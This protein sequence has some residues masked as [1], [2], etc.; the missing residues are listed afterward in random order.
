MSAADR[1]RDDV[2]FAMQ[3]AEE[4]GGPEGAE[5]IGLMFAIAEEAQR[6]AAAYGSRLAVRAREAEVE[7]G[8]A[9]DLVKKV[10]DALGTGEG[11]DALVGVAAAA[12]AAERHLAHYESLVDSVDP[13][14]FDPDAATLEEIVVA[15]VERAEWRA[16][17]SEPSQPE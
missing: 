12:H 16:V 4:I 1:I 11:G 3:A 8:H 17:E 15:A 13:K 10:G 6:R 2:L 14:Y 5:Y 7:L 9:R